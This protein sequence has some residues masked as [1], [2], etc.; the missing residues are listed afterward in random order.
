MNLKKELQT[1][2]DNVDEKKLGGHH[3]PLAGNNYADNL[4]DILIRCQKEPTLH[5][6]LIKYCKFNDY[7]YFYKS[8][9]GPHSYTWT[10]KIFDS[11]KIHI[12]EDHNITL[13]EYE[14]CEII[15]HNHDRVFDAIK[16]FEKWSEE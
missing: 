15:C 5:N 1:L 3:A 9:K 14:P 8:Y 12:S 16:L 6:K 10:F 11:I 2:L 13:V 4:M 7:T